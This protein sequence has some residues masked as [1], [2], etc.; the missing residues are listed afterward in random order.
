MD[1]P[2]R[3]ILVAIGPGGSTRALQAAAALAR[4]E[5]AQLTVLAAVTRP[6]PLIA[7]SPVALPFDAVHAAATECTARLRAALEALP[8]DVSVTGLRRPG[9]VR[10]ALLAELRT[11]AYDLVVVGAGRRSRVARA[12]R[13]DA[14][15][16][17]LVV[18]AATELPAPELVP[19]GA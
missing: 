19:V 13:R 16:P 8:A 18:D 5:R 15:T 2:L 7:A 1:S 14:A 12:L 6:S 10:A 17:V 4:R 3:S 9:P 11:G